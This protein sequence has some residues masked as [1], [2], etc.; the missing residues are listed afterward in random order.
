MP[1]AKRYLALIPGTCEHIT[2]HG[3]KNFVSVIKL[4]TLRWGAQHESSTWLQ[5][6]YMGP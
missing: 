5:C 1:P 2:S 4:S 6:N 3:K